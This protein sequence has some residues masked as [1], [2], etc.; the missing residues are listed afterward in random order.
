MQ[1]TEISDVPLSFAL[2]V[3]RNAQCSDESEEYSHRGFCRLD[4]LRSSGT[5]MEEGGCCDLSERT[6]PGMTA[7]LCR[8]VFECFFV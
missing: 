1:V 5:R 7:V 3:C 8:C 4:S 2:S 6:L